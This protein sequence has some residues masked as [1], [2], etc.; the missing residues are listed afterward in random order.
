MLTVLKPGVF[1]TIQDAGRS[2]FQQYGIITSGVMDSVAFRIGNALLKQQNKAALEMTLIG[3]DFQFTKATSITLTGG[4]MH[5]KLNGHPIS[6]NQVI[7]IHA[8]DFLTCGPIMDGARSY[9]C[10]AG[11][12]TVDAI[13]TSHSTYLKAGFGGFQG[14]ALQAGD[15]LPYD[16]N[17]QVFKAT[18]V[19]V[20]NF[21]EQ[22]PI[23]VLQGTEWQQF[24]TTLQAN[25]LTQAYRISLQSDRMG[26]RLEGALPIQ[27]EPS[28]QLLSEAVTFGTIQIPPNGQPIVLMAD[29]QTTGGYPKIA[30]VIHA[31]LHHLAQ[32]VPKQPISFQVVTLQE[33]ECTS[34]QL[35]QQLSLLEAL[36]TNY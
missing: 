29:R 17:T 33:A 28:V 11:G 19:V 14:R 22:H 30:Q 9:L 31:D 21:Y 35:E 32:L 25:F 3:G 18:Q 2:G 36:L 34:I 12:F 16:E 23:R 20:Q 7:T 27:I 13:L 15:V 24:S 10:I 6:M 4:V 8:K 1:S 26:F 5:A